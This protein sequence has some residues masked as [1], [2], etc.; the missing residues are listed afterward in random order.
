M[1]Y[2]PIIWRDRRAERDAAI[3]VFGLVLPEPS[4]ALFIRVAELNR[5]VICNEN[6]TALGS[7]REANANRLARQPIDLMKAR[8]RRV[9]RGHVP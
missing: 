5:W 2:F 1:R 4:E 6:S 7:V 9:L 3:R 8:R